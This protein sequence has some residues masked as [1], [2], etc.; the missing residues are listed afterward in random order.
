MILYLKVKMVQA[1]YRK[2]WGK[3]RK[4]G[5]VLRSRGSRV[6]LSVDS[7]LSAIRAIP[8]SVRHVCGQQQQQQGEGHEREEETDHDAPSER[9]ERVEFSLARSILLLTE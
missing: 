1:T 7:V 4:R 5:G 6:S 8:S 3:E 9:K 2:S